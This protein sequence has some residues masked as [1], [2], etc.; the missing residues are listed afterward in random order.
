MLNLSCRILHGATTLERSSEQTLLKQREETIRK[1][2][3]SSTHL[4]SSSNSDEDDKSLHYM[5]KIC[6]DNPYMS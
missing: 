6:E 5:Q 2:V 4:S 3:P 1:S